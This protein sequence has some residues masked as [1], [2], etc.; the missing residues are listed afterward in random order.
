MAARSSLYRHFARLGYI[1]FSYDMVGYTIAARS[2]RFPGG[3]GGTLG[4]ASSA[5]SCGTASG[6]LFLEQ[7]P[8][9]DKTTL[10]SLVPRKGGG[11]QTFLLT[12]VETGSLYRR[13]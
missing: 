12:A 8:E 4:S 11:T 5:F 7:M 9:V 10:A 6:R 13:P 2:P 1:V 3:P